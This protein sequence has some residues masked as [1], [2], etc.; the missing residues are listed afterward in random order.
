M[1]EDTYK[2]VKEVSEGLYKEK[3]SKFFAF[4]HPVENVDAVKLLL[5]RYHKTYHDARHICYAYS[6]G[7]EG[8]DFRVNDDGEPSGTAGRPIY[9]QIQLYGL[10]NVLMVVIRYFGGILLGTGGLVVAYK[11]AAAQALQ[12]AEIIEK[13]VDVDFNFRFEF[14]F[15]NDVMQIVKTM[16]AQILAQTYEVD[17][18]M[19]LRI[20]RNDAVRLDA[21]L[22]KVKTLTFIKRSQN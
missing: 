1:Q 22:S 16:D 8:K 7:P 13:T 4:L 17:C 9:G 12:V 21:A 5:D 6:I 19:L 3:G 15:M 20:R 14:P 2:T 11:S 10:T 18:I